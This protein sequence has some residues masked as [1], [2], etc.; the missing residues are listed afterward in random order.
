[1]LDRFYLL[2]LSGDRKSLGSA[3]SQDAVFFT[4]DKV[5]NYE[6]FFADFGPLNLSKVHRFCEIVDAKL[7]VSSLKRPML[8]R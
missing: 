4:V 5:L 8:Q 1:M 3:N 2:C 6:P 7:A